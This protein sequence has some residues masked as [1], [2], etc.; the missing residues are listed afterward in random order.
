M[1]NQPEIAPTLPQKGPKPPAKED[2]E[3]DPEPSGTSI[4]WNSGSAVQMVVQNSN[5][6]GSLL[7]QL[8]LNAS[9]EEASSGEGQR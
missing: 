1:G 9:E 6:S 3:K 5:G 2:Y 7:R 8:V 4:Q